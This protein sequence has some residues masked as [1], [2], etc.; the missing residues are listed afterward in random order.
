MICEWSWR[1]SFLM[2]FLNRNKHID[3][4]FAKDLLE[5][6]WR[7]S[8]SW[9]LTAKSPCRFAVS[10]CRS[11]RWCRNVTHLHMFQPHLNKPPRVSWSC[12]RVLC[13]MKQRLASPVVFITA[14]DQVLQNTWHVLSGERQHG[15]ALHPT[16]CRNAHFH[17]V[18]K[19]FMISNE[20]H[21]INEVHHAVPGVSLGARASGLFSVV[22]HP[23]TRSVNAKP[24]GQDVRKR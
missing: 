3:T 7:L 2:L 19:I 22:P 16:W 17:I 20:R 11:W 15:R 9:P 21:P 8:I 10:W 6:V 4:V 23:P 24:G 18:G 1:R 14:E 12:V 5:F 13:E